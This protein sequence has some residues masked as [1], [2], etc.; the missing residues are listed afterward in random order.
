MPPKSR[1]HLPTY[2]RLELYRF[3][4]LKTFFTI[5]AFLGST[6]RALL[7]KGKLQGYKQ[8][9]IDLRKYKAS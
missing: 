6:E 4:D 9:T 8:M 7:H 1:P 5:I 3:L 2:V